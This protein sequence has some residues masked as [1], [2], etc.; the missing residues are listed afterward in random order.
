MEVTLMQTAT[1]QT[2]PYS[3]FQTSTER[4]IYI[5]LLGLNIIL[6]LTLNTLGLLVLHRVHTIQATGK[7]FLR[8]LTISDIGI[9]LFY[10]L[11]S[12]V[13]ALRPQITT[14]RASCSFKVASGMLLFH[15]NI[16]SVLILTVDRYVSIVH[17]LRYPSIMTVPRARTLV[18]VLWA[19][20]IK[21]IAQQE[22][23]S[24]NPALRM[25]FKAK[26]LLTFCIIV[27]SLAV[28]WLPEVIALMVAKTTRRK[29]DILRWTF[30][31]QNASCWL[32]MVIYYLRN[33]DFRQTAH[34]IFTTWLGSCKYC[35]STDVRF[36]H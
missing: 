31:L 24:A 20:S 14:G 33:K 15:V 18:C 5:A 22:F 19:L 34:G 10:A 27:L 26:S 2:S 35:K 29:N 4:Y 21:R 30:V 16:L 25:R 9:A 3:D 23:P 8:S 12:L 7:V 28:C 6:N 17:C 32:N 1:S 36:E 13:R 11:P